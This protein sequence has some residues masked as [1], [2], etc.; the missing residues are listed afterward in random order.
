MKQSAQVP[1]EDRAAPKRTGQIMLLMLDMAGRCSTAQQPARCTEPA[2]DPKTE[3]GGGGVVIDGAALPQR[4][5]A[6]GAY[7][8]WGGAESKQAS[9]S[10]TQR[11]PVRSRPRR[12]LRW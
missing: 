4:T 1:T 2:K 10:H 12:S 11:K 8:S 5:A 3:N 6:S 9:R 7:A